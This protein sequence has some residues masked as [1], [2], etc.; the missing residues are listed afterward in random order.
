MLKPVATIELIL[1]D[2]TSSTAAV[3]VNVPSGSTLEQVDA[4]AVTLASLVLPMTDCVLVK[5]RISW[6]FQYEDNALPDSGA[7][8]AQCGAFIFEDDGGV[9]AGLVTIPSLKDDK[10]LDTGNGAGVLVD[11]ADSD[12]SAMIT[13]ILDAAA[14]NA[15]GVPFSQLQAAYRQSRV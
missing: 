1:M 14:S 8:V 5:Y 2:D 7:G 4:S 13:G 3:A 15:L 9:T 11:L 10:L 6:R 12:V